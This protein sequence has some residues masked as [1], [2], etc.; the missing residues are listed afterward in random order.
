MRTGW[1]GAT[2]IVTAAFFYQHRYKEG[3]AKINATEYYKIG[4][5]M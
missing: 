1:T 5:K 3:T 4:G 2:D